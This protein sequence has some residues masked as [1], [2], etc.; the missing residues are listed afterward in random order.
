MKQFFLLIGC[1]TWLI[2]TADAFAQSSI[3]ADR[4]VIYMDLKMQ[5][6]TSRSFENPSSRIRE[7]YDLC[8]CINYNKIPNQLVDRMFENIG[9]SICIFPIQMTEVRMVLDFLHKDSILCSLSICN[10]GMYFLN[11]G[12]VNEVYYNCSAINELLEFIFDEKFLEYSMT[13]AFIE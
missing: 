13:G 12:M 8:C 2:L 3:Q 5:P 4:L 6:L 1:A 10:G 9:D 7:H 11:D